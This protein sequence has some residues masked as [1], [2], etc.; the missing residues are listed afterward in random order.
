M[1]RPAA[2]ARPPLRPGWRALG[3]GAELRPD[4]VVAGLERAEHQAF[5]GPRAI[6]PGLRAAAARVGARHPRRR[7]Q[8]RGRPRGPLAGGAPLRR[9]DL[10]PRSV[11][12]RPREALLRRRRSA[13]VRGRPARRAQADRT[14]PAGDAPVRQRRHQDRHDRARL[15]LGRRPAHR[16]GQDRGGPGADARPGLRPAVE[17]APALE[18]RAG[19]LVRLARPEPGAG[20]L[21]LL[22]LQRAAH[23][24]RPAQA[25][26]D[27]LSGAG[28]ARGCAATG[29]RTLCRPGNRRRSDPAAGPTARPAR[30]R[31][32]ARR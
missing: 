27:G 28:R 10:S 1:G 29:W 9:L 14:G 23:T 11:Q 19:L 22:P 31:S 15:G 26:L 6:R 17:Q 25:G 4:H 5:L 2:G 3:A 24:R 21:R 13:P 30:S 32:A 12:G 7:L 18:H 16:L 20:H 8:C